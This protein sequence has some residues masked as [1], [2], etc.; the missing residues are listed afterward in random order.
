MVPAFV[1]TS[2]SIHYTKLYDGRVKSYETLVDRARREAIL[3][4]KEAARDQ[5]AGMVINRITSYNVCY[6]KLLRV[7]RVFVLERIN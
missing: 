1:I 5:G 6:T 2:Y 7:D 4:M 3:R